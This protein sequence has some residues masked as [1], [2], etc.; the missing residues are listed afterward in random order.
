M[1]EKRAAAG[2]RELAIAY[3]TKDCSYLYKVLQ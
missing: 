3:Y 2:I 1:V